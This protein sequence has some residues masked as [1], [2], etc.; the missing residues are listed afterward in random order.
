MILD[1]SH[2]DRERGENVC[3]VSQD[4]LASLIRSYSDLSDLPMVEKGE[5]LIDPR[6][7]GSFQTLEGTKE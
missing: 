1:S 2:R 6:G 4:E 3:L 7:Q 5:I